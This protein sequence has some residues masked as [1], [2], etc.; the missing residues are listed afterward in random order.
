M[1]PALLASW[2]LACIE[3]APGSGSRRER[4]PPA[5]AARYVLAS[6]E[7]RIAVGAVYGGALELVG[8]DLDPPT[9]CAGRPTALTLYW[10]VLAEP[11]ARWDVFVHL[12]GPGVP[13]VHGDHAPARGAY[14]TTAWRRGEI[15]RDPLSLTLPADE[16]ASVLEAWVGLFAGAERMPV[17]RAGPLGRDGEDRALVARI[18]VLCQ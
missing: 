2:A 3:R 5:V 10:R 17:T 4:V 8:L 15:V 14:P 9:L 12:D 16:P 18:P 11:E 13:R 7:P 6:V 1:L